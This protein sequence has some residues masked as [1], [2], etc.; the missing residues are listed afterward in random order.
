MTAKL[1][2]ALTTESLEDGAPE[3]RAGYGIL[4]ILTRGAYL[5]EGFDHYSEA[6]RRGPLVSGYY[7]AEWLA[8]HWWRLRWEPRRRDTDWMLAHRMTSVG[9]GYVW[10][11]ITVFS[12]GYRTALIAKPS[13][14]PDAKPFRY[15]REL[16]STVPASEWEDAVD[17]FF[18][19]I[20]ARLDADD[21]KTTNLHRLLDDLR[22]ERADP[23]LAH[24]RRIEALFGRD[25]ER[26]RVFYRGD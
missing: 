16:T 26:L 24:L 22:A 18:L 3:E 9:A 10:P 4:S 20:V 19:H 23:K 25:P 13:S 6:Y 2:I 12:D 5:S 17:D 14:R 21:L 8:W 15:T 11:N 7:L 1:E